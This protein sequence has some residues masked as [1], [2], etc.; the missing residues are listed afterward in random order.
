LL[1]PCA[2]FPPP[3]CGTGREKEERVESG[4]IRAQSSGAGGPGNCP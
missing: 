2:I 1:M 3:S 4:G